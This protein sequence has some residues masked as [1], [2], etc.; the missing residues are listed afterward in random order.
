MHKSATKCNKILG[1]WCKN[2][3]GAS[4][5]ID[6]L[7]TYHTSGYLDNLYIVLN[8][9]QYHMGYQYEGLE[10]EVYQE[11]VARLWSKFRIEGKSW[12]VFDHFRW[13]VWWK[14]EEAPKGRDWHKLRSSH[15]KL[16]TVVGQWK[17]GAFKHTRERSQGKVL[18][19]KGQGL[20]KEG[21]SILVKSVLQF[22]SA[23]TMRCFHF[24]K[25]LC[26]QLSSISSRFWW[27]ASDGQRMVHWISWDK[28]AEVNKK[29]VWA[30]GIM[31]FSIK[32][33]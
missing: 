24:S 12:K 5:I 16:P 21:G 17:E 29:V 10:F 25:N 7:E 27:G 33:C 22:V 23:Y 30:F 6:T 9:L 13:W 32:P 14:Q 20:S 18:G 19:L 28:C 11:G 2:K 31:N 1:K 3:H 4:K 8:I 26:K 15:G